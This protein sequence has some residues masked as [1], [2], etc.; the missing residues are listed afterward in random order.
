MDN[1]TALFRWA[2]PRNVRWNVIASCV[3][4]GNFVN[5]II[6][7]YPDLDTCDI[8]NSALRDLF[9]SALPTY[10][11]E[12]FRHSTTQQI[13]SWYLSGCGTN[14]TYATCDT[15]HCLSAVAFKQAI[16][17]EIKKS[18]NMTCIREV[19]SSL[20]IQGNADIAGVGVMVTFCLEA[21][22]VVGFLLAQAVEQVHQRNS[23]QPNPFIKCITNAFKVVLPEFYWSSVLLSLG[24]VIASLLTAAASAGDVQRDRL[25]QWKA[26]K[27]FTVYDTQLAALASLFSIQATFMAGLILQTS[28]RR[29]RLLNVAILPLL[30]LFLVVLTYLTISLDAQLPENVIMLHWSMLR[31]DELARGFLQIF[32]G[33]TMFMM[34][35]CGVTA[36]ATAWA[37]RGKAKQKGALPDNLLRFELWTVQTILTALMLATLGKFFDFR[38][39]T[40]PGSAA[41]DPQLEWSFGQILVLTTW[42]P[43]MLDIWYT[44]N[45]GIIRGLEVHMPGGFHAVT[46]AEFKKILPQTHDKNQGLEQESNGV[47]QG[48]PSNGRGEEKSASDIEV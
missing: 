14:A 30:G 6:R 42:I 21:S 23:R 26:G 8:N 48:S 35:I 17:S 20:G 38:K 4:F 37:R 34:G 16:L 24:M 47:L 15:H 1:N 3:T 12:G 31:T 40:I 27:A 22:L 44:S 29:R 33:V 25:R 39:Q 41:G 10:I 11:S 7:T 9:N 13:A 43:V 45:V 28:G 2:P 36:L 18:W 32:T 19:R 5:S 46:A